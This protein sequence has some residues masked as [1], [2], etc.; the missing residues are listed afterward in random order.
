MKPCADRPT[1]Y[2]IELGMQQFNTLD[3]QNGEDT[4][5]RKTKKRANDLHNY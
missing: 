1:Q 2:H 3:S 4:L 5:M